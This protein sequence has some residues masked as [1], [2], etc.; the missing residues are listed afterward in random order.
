M[1]KLAPWCLSCRRFCEVFPDEICISFLET[2]QA[3][4]VEP[5]K[6]DTRPAPHMGRVECDREIPRTDRAASSATESRTPVRELHSSL[7]D[8]EKEIGSMHRLTIFTWVCLVL[9][10]PVLAGAQGLG[11]MS[12]TVTDPSG[13]VVP[14]A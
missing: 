9:A 8:G 1:D 11:S 13:A 3:P 2:L 12:G 6:R 10:L 4:S 7:A 5:G 14:S